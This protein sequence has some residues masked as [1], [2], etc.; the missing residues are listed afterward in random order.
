MNNEIENIH[1]HLRVVE[2]RLDDLT[3]YGL[4]VECASLRALR[5]NLDAAVALSKNGETEKREGR[6]MPSTQNYE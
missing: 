1:R 4:V 2:N 6:D 3:R 5:A